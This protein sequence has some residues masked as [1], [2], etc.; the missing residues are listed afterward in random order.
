MKS[1]AIKLFSLLFVLISYPLRSH[2]PLI[3]VSFEL[4]IDKKLHKP[5]ELI[6]FTLTISNNDLSRTYPIVL[7]GTQR[8][9][10]KFIWFQAYSVSRNFYT[11]VA[12]ENMEVQMENADSGDI[13][14]RNLRP[15]QS[16]KVP[17]FMND[18]KNY[19]KQIAS[20]H[21][22]EPDLKDG[23]YEVLVYYNPGNTPFKDLYHY[24]STT[25]DSLS[26]QKLNLWQGG[27]N[28]NYVSLE[29]KGDP[30]KKEKG[31]SQT[32]TSIHKGLCFSRETLQ[33]IDLKQNSKSASSSIRQYDFKQNFTLLFIRPEFIS[34]R[35]EFPIV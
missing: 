20:H 11:C 28:T 9:G 14:V 18:K 27:Q 6:Q 23:P 32:R 15:G 19:F 26:P 12:K 21:A 16:I 22:F 30:Q 1:I 33:C 10:K 7:P 8:K 24:I 3:P 2:L 34:L 35:K 31:Q 4:S 25:E 5:G 13:T 29:I 17:L